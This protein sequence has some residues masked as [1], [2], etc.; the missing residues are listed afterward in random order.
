MTADE[1]AETARRFL[2]HADAYFA[3]GDDLQVSE[4]LWGAAVHAVTAVEKDRGW[5]FR[6]YTAHKDAVRS[7]AAETGV[8]DLN[9]WFLEANKLHVNFYLGDLIPQ[10]IEKIRTKVRGFVLQVLAI[11]ERA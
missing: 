5:R 7:L 8:N 9:K 11:R 1:H 3:A 4:K 6:N 2:E 10:D